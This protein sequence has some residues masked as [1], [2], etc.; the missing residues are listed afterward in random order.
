MVRRRFVVALIL[1]LRHHPQ[2][3][4][5]PLGL[6]DP[7]AQHLLV[8]GSAYADG[9]VHRLVLDRPFVTDLDAQ[10]VPQVGASRRSRPRLSQ[11]PVKE[12]E[13]VASF[14]RIVSNP[15]RASCEKL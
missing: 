2:P 5:G 1:D 6:L 3:E 4:L 14:Q 7:D 15:L 9:Q 11:A 8:P 10:E 12:S 13:S